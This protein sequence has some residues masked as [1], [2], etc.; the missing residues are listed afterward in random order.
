MSTPSWLA[1]LWVHLRSGSRGNITQEGKVH[2]GGPDFQSVAFCPFQITL[3]ILVAVT[4]ANYP[5]T[6]SVFLRERKVCNLWSKSMALNWG[7]L[8]FLVILAP[9]YVM[10]SHL[11]KNCSIFLLYFFLVYSEPLGLKAV[12]NVTELWMFS[13]RLVNH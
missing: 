10:S 7:S 5:F 4:R 11:S 3:E 1:E 2:Q 13:V 6:G 12:E 8:Y 9:R